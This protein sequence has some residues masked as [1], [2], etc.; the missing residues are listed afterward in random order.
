MNNHKIKLSTLILSGIGTI[1]GSGWLFGSAMA[2]KVAGPAA[3]FSWIIGAIMV[4]VIAL[5]LVEIAT[6]APTRMGS[7][8]YFLRYTHG[9]FASFIAEWTILIGFISSVPSEATASTQYLSDWNYNWTHGLF[10]HVT[11]SLTTSGMIVS[12]LLCL[13]YFLVNYYS[14]AFLTKSIKTLTLF[15]ILVPF[16]AII[17]FIYIGFNPSNLHAVGNH[18]FAPYGISGIFT[19]VTT[20][21]VVYAFNGF[22]AP[23]TFAAE[24]ENPKRNIPL[25]L[26][27]S[28]AI[29]TI[30]Y[31]ALQISYLT[32][33]P[34]DLLVQHGWN[35][36]NFSSPFASLAIALNINMVAILLYAD[37]FISPSGAGIIYA[38]LSG[39][40][41]CG[42]GEHMPKFIG[43][44]DYKTRLPRNAL[45]IV[46]ILSFASLWLLP[47]WDRL[48]AVI[49]VG[50]VLCYATVPVSTYSFR[51]LSPI[52]PHHNAI[53]I[54]GMKLFAPI[55]FILATFMLYWSRWPL[56][57][58][59]IFVVLLGLP[60][61]IYYALKAQEQIK[62]QIPRTIWIIAYLIFIG[63]FGLIGSKDFGGLGI[64]P[65]K[66]AL[67]HILLAACSL[68]FFTWGV[69]VS[70]KT[71]EYINQIDKV[72]DLD[73]A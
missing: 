9:S 48:A 55:G 35:G 22:Q 27:G 51:K 23:I 3:V 32:A 39:R 63:I 5:N 30:I 65:D 72:S 28:V 58:E 70:I 42:M 56:N 2:A 21:G 71:T 34:H 1:I 4:L 66:Y 31:V 11:A 60:I 73:I 37:A 25:A 12:S 29:S 68:L 62:E 7:M 64:I 13:V 16:I 49:S 50:Y 6:I 10:N 17:S 24:A 14:L 44:L 20:A 40:V 38:S 67:D 43:Q 47:S 52:I 41:F 54:P 59:V 46:L 53:R 69:K 26:I 45:I 61:Y 8:G 18:S 36:L 15:K 33:M 19:A 57:G